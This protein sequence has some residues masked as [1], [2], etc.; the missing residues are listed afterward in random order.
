MILDYS[1]GRFSMSKRDVRLVDWESQLEI[2]QRQVR[3]KNGIQVGG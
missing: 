2:R 1:S 3:D